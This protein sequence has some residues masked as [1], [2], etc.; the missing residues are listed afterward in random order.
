[1]SAYFGGKWDA[2]VAYYTEA[3]HTS[4]DIGRDFDAAAVA[5]NRAEVLVQQGRID[6][7][8][9]LLTDAIRVLLPAE[10]TSY[11]AFAMTIHGR[12]AL[13]RGDVEQ[14]ADRFGTARQLCIDMGEADEALTADAMLAECMLVAGDPREAERMAV[15]ALRRADD[16][17]SSVPTLHRVRGE[18]SIALGDV[19]AGHAALREA[20]QAARKRGSRSEVEAALDALLRHHVASDSAEA[21]AWR[22]ESAQ[23]IVSLGIVTERS[24][25]M[26]FGSPAGAVMT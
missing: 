2:A 8:E 26:P 3:E 20:L 18:A 1:M 25:P 7:A 9:P 13:A 14:A 11:L 12:A 15:A 6:E 16:E 21:L 22:A 24:Y 4:R 19:D 23:L 10:A 17:S 5:V